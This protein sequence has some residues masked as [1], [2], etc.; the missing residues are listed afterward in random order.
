CVA[1]S[2]REYSAIFVL[3]IPL[4]AFAATTARTSGQ[5]KCGA[6]LSPFNRIGKSARERVLRSRRHARAQTRLKTSK[7]RTGD[8]RP[9]FDLR[10]RPDRAHSHRARPT[11]SRRPR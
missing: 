11:L 10:A 3:E 9:G 2:Q 4:R 5:G 7:D 1:L 8:K 6:A